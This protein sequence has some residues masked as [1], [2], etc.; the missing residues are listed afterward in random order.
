MMG[1]YT[2]INT[3]DKNKVYLFSQCIRNDK[4]LENNEIKYGINKYYRI[5]IEA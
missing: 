5:F 2:H 4:C 1:K 3:P